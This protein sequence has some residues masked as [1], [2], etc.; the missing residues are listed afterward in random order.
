MHL[1]DEICWLTQHLP[2]SFNGIFKSLQTHENHASIVVISADL[3]GIGTVHDA[4]DWVLND[5]QSVL[6]TSSFQAQHG[7]LSV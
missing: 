4:R 2:K 7:K 3:K 6:Q 5:L 1:M